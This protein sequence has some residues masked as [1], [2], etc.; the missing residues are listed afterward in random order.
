MDM[1]NYTT[2]YEYTGT[3]DDEVR[4]HNRPYNTLYTIL[5]TKQCYYGFRIN[6]IIA[7]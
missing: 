4:R 5:L 7:D 2:H 1:F 6:F 3:T